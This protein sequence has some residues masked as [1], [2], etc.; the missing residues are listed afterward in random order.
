MRAEDAGC[1]DEPLPGSVLVGVPRVRAGD[2][3]AGAG[4]AVVT[5]TTAA[6]EV[7]ER[8]VTV[9]PS[10]SAVLPP[11]GRATCRSSSRGAAGDGVPSS[12]SEV[13]GNPPARCRSTPACRPN[14][15]P[16]SHAS[17]PTAARYS[18]Q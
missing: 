4:P 6:V 12:S 8:T 15:L 11:T 10:A 2:A 5:A 3:A 14:R 7:T 18:S 9:R 17:W 1:T 16:A 13:S